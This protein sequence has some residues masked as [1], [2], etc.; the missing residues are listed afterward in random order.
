MDVGEF[1]GRKETVYLGVKYN[2]W[3]NKFGFDGLNEHNPQLQ[4]DWKF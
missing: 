4:L 1:F 3:R 2:Y